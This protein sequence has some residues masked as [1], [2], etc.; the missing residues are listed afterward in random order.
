LFLNILTPANNPPTA[1]ALILVLR[2]SLEVQMFERNVTKVAPHK[3]LKSIARG[4]LTV[5]ERVVLQLVVRVPPLKALVFVLRSSLEV[6][7]S[8]V[9]VNV[10]ESEGESESGSESV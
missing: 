7:P 6:G 2:S 8:G 10:C 9:C 5:E 3:A 4:K 1:E